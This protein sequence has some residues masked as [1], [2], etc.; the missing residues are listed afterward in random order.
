MTGSSTV[1]THSDVSDE[2][3][4]IAQATSTKS[5]AESRYIVIA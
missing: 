4:A 5:A 3:E 1:V 2:D